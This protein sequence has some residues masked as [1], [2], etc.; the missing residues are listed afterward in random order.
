MP[1]SFFSGFAALSLA[2]LLCARAHAAPTLTHAL[3][4]LESEVRA[5]SVQPGRLVPTWVA[6]PPGVAFVASPMAL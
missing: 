2:T 4:E 5:G 1:R 6:F 3:C